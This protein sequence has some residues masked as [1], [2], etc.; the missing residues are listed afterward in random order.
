VVDTRSGHGACSRAPTVSAVGI[1]AGQV[2][3]VPI[4]SVS[5][6]P[7]DATAVVLNVTAVGATRPTYISVYPHGGS[8]PAVSNL[9]VGSALPVPNLVIVRVTDGMIDFFN[10]AGSVNLIA[11]LAG[12]YEPS[13]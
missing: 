12:Y 1:G 8:R 4:T 3:T 5:G 7:A 11:D 13:S 2:L 9:N 6:V 10:A